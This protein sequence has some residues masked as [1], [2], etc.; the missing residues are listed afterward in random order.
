MKVSGRVASALYWLLEFVKFSRANTALFLLTVVAFV[1]NYIQH[2]IPGSIMFGGIAVMISLRLFGF[3]RGMVVALAA[4]IGASQFS[5]VTGI[6]LVLLLEAAF[7]GGALLSKKLRN[8]VLIDGVFWVVF[9][10][11]LLWSLLGESGS[12]DAWYHAL[13][14]GFNGLSNALLASIL[15]VFLPWH[16]WLQLADNQDA[17]PLQHLV[18]NLVLACVVFPAFVLTLLTIRDETRSIR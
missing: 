12:N 15:L 3:A 14:I 11:L 17:V 2:Y 9:G 8:I 10:M 4:A 7:V 6:W 5:N 1:G 18:F 16:R 13:T